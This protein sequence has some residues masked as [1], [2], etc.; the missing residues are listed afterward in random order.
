MVLDKK[1]ELELIKNRLQKAYSMTIEEQKKWFKKIQELE[2]QT[3]RLERE[4]GY[5]F[6]EEEGIK[7]LINANKELSIELSKQRWKADIDNYL[8]K[9]TKVKELLDLA[10]EEVDRGFKTKSIT[11]LSL[12]V[13]EYKKALKFVEKTYEDNFTLGIRELTSDENKVINE[14][15]EQI[16]WD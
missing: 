9:N 6:S 7:L 15:L 14:R 13:L 12:K 3:A 5:T 2:E 4:L 10:C 1:N 8:E 11:V 16:G